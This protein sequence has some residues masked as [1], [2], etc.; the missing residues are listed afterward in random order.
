VR[1]GNWPQR[2]PDY[3][4]V[5]TSGA[6]DPL[7][8]GSPI[9]CVRCKMHRG[10]WNVSQARLSSPGNNVLRAVSGAVDATLKLRGELNRPQPA[11]ELGGEA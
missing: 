10:A 9:H 11:P 3:H 2:I 7:D 6:H 1:F 8:A 5:I 4:M